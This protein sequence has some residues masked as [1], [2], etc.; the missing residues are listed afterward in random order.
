LLPPRRAADYKSAIRQIEN[1]RYE[2][3]GFLGYLDRHFRVAPAKEFR[4]GILV[5]FIC[6][7]HSPPDPV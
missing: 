6:G 3:G 7:E 5:T 2:V 1:L 4:S